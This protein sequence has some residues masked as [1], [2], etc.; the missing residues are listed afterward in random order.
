MELD[1]MKQAWQ[2]MSARLDALQTG[3]DGLRLDIGKRRAAQPLRWTRGMLGFETFS[4]ALMLVLLALF[5]AHQS[6]WRFIAPA[7]ILYPP[8][9][10]LFASSVWQ[11]FRL[12]RLDY[13]ASVVTIQQQL[14][15]LYLL[16]LRTLQLNV[17]LVCL[18]WVPVAIVGMWGV[19]GV[20][21]YNWNS[22]WLVAGVVFGVLLIPVLWWL[23]R[24]LGRAFG[25]TAPGRFLLEDVTGHGLAAA[26]RRLAALADFTADAK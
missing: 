6:Q 4:N 8:S 15:R 20:D 25:R 12:A 17:L 23:S 2:A 7:L 26:R 21:L 19:F 11:L 3:Y 24:R 13:G 1:E 9:I 10:A 16:R 5:I 22:A 14:E 18:L